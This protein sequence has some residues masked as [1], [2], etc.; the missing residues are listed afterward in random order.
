MIVVLLIGF[1][2]L[3][4]KIYSQSAINEVQKAD[5]IVVLGAAQWNGNPS[6]VFKSRLDHALNLYKSDYAS[7]IILTGGIGK[8]ESTSESSVGKKYLIQKG[9][10]E[11]VIYIEEQGHTTWQSLNQVAQ[12]IKNQNLD[13][14]ILVSDG[15]HMMRLKKMS[16][17]LNIKSL[18]SPVKNSLIGKAKMVEFK[19]ILREAVVYIAYLLFRI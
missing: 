8:E 3:I 7:K 18:A 13:S 6:P 17:D 1:S 16:K 11:S 9:V 15:F 5:A 4:F 14:V 10:G 19:Y 2:I 12:I